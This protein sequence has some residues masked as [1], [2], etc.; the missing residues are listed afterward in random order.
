MPKKKTKILIL[1]LI[2]PF[3]LSAFSFPKISFATIFFSYDGE[4]GYQYM[5]AGNAF[6]GGGYFTQMGGVGL[7]SPGIL[8][9]AGSCVN[10]TVN[11]TTY[12]Y[13]TN[14]NHYTLVS[15]DNSST[16]TS[17]QDPNAGGAVTGSHCS[18]KTPYTAACTDEGYQR[19][20]TI[21]NFGQTLNEYYIRWYQKW[22]GSW[23]NFTV[24]QKFFKP[25]DSNGCTGW[26]GQLSFSWSNHPNWFAYVPNIDGHFNKD[27]ITRASYVWVSATRTGQR[28]YSAGCEYNGTTCAYD[29]DP[30]TTSDFNFT[31]NIWYSLEIHVKVNTANNSDGLMEAWVNG[32]KVLGIYNLKWYSGTPY[33]VNSV[34][35][36]HINY[37][38]P[39]SNDATYMD[40]IVIADQYI[41]PV[42]TN[43][44]GDGVCDVNAGETCVTCPA[45]CSCADTT[46]PSPPSGVSVN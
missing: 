27:G 32:N 16:N 40:N 7:N 12:D 3:L 30:T 13:D 9:T 26:P 19:D 1:F 42:A 44:C 35:L 33:G 25:C 6:P 4:N 39:A 24:Q 38:R 29:D 18:L 14:N 17:P 10:R 34:E 31:T 36:Q 21:I 2:L 28:A 37:N 45:D 11:P 15:C 5:G 43:P 46:P 22:T 20:T 23:P 8:P 41:G